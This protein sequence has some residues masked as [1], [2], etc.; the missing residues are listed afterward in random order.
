MNLSAKV[1]LVLAGAGLATAGAFATKSVLAETSPVDSQV[2][3]ATTTATPP[4]G[5]PI[6]GKHQERFDEMAALLGMTS[7]ELQTELAS[8]KEFYQIAAAHGVT[9][10]KLKSNAEAKHKA[11]LDD[12]VKVGFLTQDQADA[13]LKQYQDNSQNMPMFGMGM[14]MERGFHHGIGF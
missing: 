9:Y 10:D 6:A 12:M 2:S 14:G 8:G 4:V 3:V 5:M 7:T 13:M 1:A 11:R